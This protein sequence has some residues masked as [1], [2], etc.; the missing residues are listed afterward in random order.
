MKK[1]E[2]T[3]DYATKLAGIQVISLSESREQFSL[4]YDADLY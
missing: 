3:L 1:S 4:K 2:L